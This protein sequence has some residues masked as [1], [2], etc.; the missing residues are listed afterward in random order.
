MVSRDSPESRER[1]GHHHR[2]VAE[3]APQLEDRHPHRVG[4]RVGILVPRLL[5]QL[6]RG[7][8]GAIGA[9]QLGQDRE[10]L[11]RQRHVAAVAGHLAAVGVKADAGALQDRR[12]GRPGAPS[13]RH[14]PRGQ[15][16]ERERLGQVVVGAQGQ[17]GDPLVDL[18]GGGQQQHPHR[19]PA[20]HQRLAHLVA[21]HDRQ[22]T[23]QH[24]HVV[25]VDAD[26]FQRRSAVVDHV[27]GVRVAAQPL[28][29]RVGQQR[30]VL[31]HQDP[32]APMVP[33]AVSHRRQRIW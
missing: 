32:H 24:H 31:D 25:V 15:L 20:R 10:L 18:G 17:P 23:V 9:Q 28:G 4:E 27:H 6:L 7:D 30:L 8:R 13:Q 14:H 1:P 26:A 21:V 33:Q 3:L 5:Q 29:H 12:R 2:W 11:A 16:R 22:V 19:P